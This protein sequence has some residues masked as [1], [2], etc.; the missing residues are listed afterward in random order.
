MNQEDFDN[1]SEG[2]WILE[3][4]R[5]EGNVKCDKN[6]GVNGFIQGNVVGEKRVWI[7]GTGV[8]DGNVDCSELYLDGIITGNACVAR[9]AFLGKN[10]EI[11]GALVAA[12]LEIVPGAKIGL[13]LKLKNTSK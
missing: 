12:G 8:V 13:G 6:I 4:T 2:C 10:A 9:Q 11:K 5:I 3:G 1:R 7:A